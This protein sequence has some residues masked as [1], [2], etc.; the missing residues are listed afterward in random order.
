MTLVGREYLRVSADRS[1][2]Q[3][4]VTEQ[5]T[6]N[7]RGAREH[8]LTLGEAYRETGAV[9][10][11]RFSTKIRDGYDELLAD[12]RR[13][14]FGADV[15][16]MWESS[17]G[18]RR[19]GE[20]A[21]LLDLLEDNGVRV[22][23]T[24]HGRIYDP[25]NGRDR[26]SMLEDAVDSEYESSKISSRVTRAM[27]EQ[28]A[29]GRP[30]GT[31][32]Y[33]YL[34]VFDPKTGRLLN[35]E[36]DPE[37]A[38]VIKELFDRIRSGDSFRSIAKDFGERGIVNGSGT[39][40]S[41]PHLRDMA[42]KAVYAG[43]RPHKGETIEGTW[44][45]IVDRAAFFD[46]QRIVTAPERKTSRSG[47]AVHELTMTIRCDVCSGPM[48]VTNRT[49]PD[50]RDR[51]CCQLKG[52]AKIDKEGVD[53][54]VIGV[55]LGYLAR[56]DVYDGLS[57]SPDN[58]AE[59]V[60]LDGEISRA[61]FD[62][63]EAENAVP[64]SISEAKMFARAVDGL[65]ETLTDLEARR[66]ALTTPPVLTEFLGREGDMAERWKATPISARREI[67][68]ILLV[69]ELLGEVRIKRSASAGHRRPAIER[70]TWRR[71]S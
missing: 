2:R 12:L 47:R 64:G 29:D 30:H 66:R 36:P 41:A 38:P 3:A 31:C 45:P 28:A 23:V 44:E 13:G 40:F 39:P 70:V 32:P 46:V 57:A 60:R 58:D 26:R 71:D 7:E 69:P 11:S 16:I 14:T 35:W 21:T 15:L 63:A 51:Y 55:I 34:R 37:R 20:W 56:E 5:H 61:R 25:S 4:S 53:E 67:A 10:A 43:L 62:L 19:V 24:T 33:G 49:T 65:T 27:A 42:I 59:V 17:R 18:S 68:R 1:G 54:I 48:I 22:L 50:G 52:C 6:A 9:S 8:G